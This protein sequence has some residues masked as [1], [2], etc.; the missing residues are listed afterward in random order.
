[1]QMMTSKVFERSK[2]SDTVYKWP[3][4][5]IIVKVPWQIYEYPALPF[6]NVVLLLQYLVEACYNLL[7]R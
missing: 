1:M 5:E 4:K 7:A 6:L 3:G 2:P